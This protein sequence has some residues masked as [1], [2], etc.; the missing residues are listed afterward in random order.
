MPQSC[1]APF[2]V[3]DF[4]RTGWTNPSDANAQARHYCAELEGGRILFF[5]EL[6]FNLPKQDTEYLIS[7]T[8][9]GSKLHKNISYRPVKQVLRGFSG[10]REEEARARAI[11]RNYSAEVTKF[12]ASCLTPYSGKLKLDFASFR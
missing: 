11:L 7:R 8:Y 10:S 12:V 9:S 1:P 4:G 2:E 3:T 6:P 5:S